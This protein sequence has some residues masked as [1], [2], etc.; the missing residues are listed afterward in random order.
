MLL[1]SVLLSNFFVDWSETEEAAF[2]VAV[3]E[4]SLDELQSLLERKRLR[5]KPIVILDEFSS[6]ESVGADNAISTQHSSSSLEPGT[7]QGPM[8]YVAS[9]S[10]AR[11]YAVKIRITMK[12]PIKMKW[13][14]N[15]KMRIIRNASIKDATINEIKLSGSKLVTFK[16][17]V[18]ITHIE[19]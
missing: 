2:S 4:K 5:N 9:R 11:I 18:Q 3:V 19:E 17:V 12:R 1:I 6:L 13:T 10:Y 14:A 15:R 16:L 7:R 8:G